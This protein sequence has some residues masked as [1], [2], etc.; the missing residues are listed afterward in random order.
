MITV[1]GAIEDMI[2]FYLRS[3]IQIFFCTFSNL[4]YI[5][6]DVGSAPVEVGLCYLVV[7]VQSKF[8]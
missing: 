5:L 8:L 7:R 1:I 6:L 3:I 4:Y 2:V